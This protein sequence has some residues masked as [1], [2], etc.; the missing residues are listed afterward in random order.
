MKLHIQGVWQNACEFIRQLA[1]C[2]IADE[3]RLVG[4]CFS[5]VT[6]CFVCW[7]TDAGDGVV[8][9][10]VVTMTMVAMTK[11]FVG[12]DWWQLLGQDVSMCCRWWGSCR[13]DAVANRQQAADN[14]QDGPRSPGCHDDTRLHQW[15]ACRHQEAGTWCCRISRRFHFSHQRRVS[16]EGRCSFHE[17]CWFIRVLQT[18]V[19]VMWYDTEYQHHISTAS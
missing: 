1:H 6:Y 15:D 3:E 10:T 9:M 12:G 4:C 8:A 5:F 2:I 7:C 17:K 13:D 19:S 16:T 18:I 11:M 14:G